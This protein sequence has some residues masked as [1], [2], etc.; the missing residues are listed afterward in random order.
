[1]LKRCSIRTAQIQIHWF[2]RWRFER[3]AVYVSPK[4]SITSQNH[5][6]KH[7]MMSRPMSER[8]APSV[9]Q[10]YTILSPKWP[11]RMV[12]LRYCPTC[13]P[14][15]MP[16][17]LLCFVRA[18][19]TRLKMLETGG[20]EFALCA[21]WDCEKCGCKR[22]EKSTCDGRDPAWQTDV[23]SQWVHRVGSD[24][25]AGSLDVVQ[26]ERRQRSR[27]NHRKSLAKIIASQ[28]SR[29]ARWCEIVAELSAGD[30]P[31]WWCP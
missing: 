12:L 30:E 8:Q 5:F 21:E 18:I 28:C 13:C 24:H 19:N 10:N 22:S 2:E 17:Y 6:V 14:T 4:S 26:A 7:C 29:C 9:W 16:L 3:W 11:L 25:I 27:Q 23:D 31:G 20:G 1:M 15:G